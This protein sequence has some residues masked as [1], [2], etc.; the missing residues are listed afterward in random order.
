MITGTVL[1]RKIIIRINS[2]SAKCINDL[3]KSGKIQAEII[4]DICI[5][6]HIQR[7]HTYV[8]TIDSCMCKFIRYSIG[9]R[10]W[11]I[12]I[13]WGGN[14]QY[15]FGPRIDCKDDIYITSTWSCNIAPCIDTTD[16]N[17]INLIC[18]SCIL[19]CVWRIL[20]LYICL[21][22]C[23]SITFYQFFY[24]FRCNFTDLRRKACI[25]VNFIKNI[26]ICSVKNNC[27]T[28]AFQKSIGKFCKAAVFFGTYFPTGLT[29]HLL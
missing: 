5:I 8:D 11:Y 17:R 6:K 13:S 23:R 10:K 25:I 2:N 24:L 27:L 18:Y 20:C 1:C 15:L 4:I 14:H 9:N 12:I 16:K 7:I 19:G 22:R 21:N 28:V 29:C 26:Q 3:H